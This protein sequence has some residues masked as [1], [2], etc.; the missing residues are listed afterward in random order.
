M[1][2]L[3]FKEAASY[4]LGTAVGTGQPLPFIQYLH[5][6]HDCHLA[7]CTAD[8]VQVTLQGRKR[9]YSLVSR[10]DNSMYRFMC[11]LRSFFCY[12]NISNK[13]VMWRFSPLWHVKYLSYC[14]LILC[15]LIQGEDA[16]HWPSWDSWRSHSKWWVHTASPQKTK[17][18]KQDRTCT[19]SGTPARTWKTERFSETGTNS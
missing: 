3:Y 4:R 16:A 7:M 10:Q 6:T 2:C 15:F 8:H 18:L 17:H 5:Q 14:A 13:D 11:N 19:E 9:P 12:K 1:K